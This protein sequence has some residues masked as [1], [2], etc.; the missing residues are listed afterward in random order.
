[1]A[2]RS[3][4]ESRSGELGLERE[5]DLSAERER[6]RGFPIDSNLHH[7]ADDLLRLGCSATAREVGLHGGEVL[8]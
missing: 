7:V 6:K 8:G 2:S 1:M 5:K 3:C 4:K